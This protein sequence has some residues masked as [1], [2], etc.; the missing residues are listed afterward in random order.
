MSKKIKIT[1]EHAASATKV[2]AG[3]VLA[4]AGPLLG[5]IGLKELQKKKK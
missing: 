3:A 5:N 4:V 2:I 1:K